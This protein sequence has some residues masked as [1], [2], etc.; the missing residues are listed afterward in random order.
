MVWR[1][2]RGLTAASAL[3]RLV[4]AVL[5]V[6]TLYVGKLIIDNVVLIVQG[7]GQ[8]ANHGAVARKADGIQ[9]LDL[10][11]IIRQKDE[12]VLTIIRAGEG[13]FKRSRSS[14]GGGWIRRGGRDCRSDAEGQETE[15]G[16]D[17]VKCE[18]TACGR[19]ISGSDGL[20]SGIEHDDEIAILPINIAVL[21]NRDPVHRG[22]RKAGA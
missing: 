19:R 11:L 2:S 1:T 10:S 4:R 14:D 12:I 16:G 3:L 20:S 22:F 18:S 9:H 5:P 17:G 6:V 7:A 21:R 15:L 8:A 13:T